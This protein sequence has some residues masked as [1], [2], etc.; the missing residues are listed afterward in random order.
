MIITLSSSTSDNSLQYTLSLTQNL[1]N[2]LA[3]GNLF[4]GVDTGGADCIVN[5]GASP[6][7]HTPPSGYKSI[8]S[9]NLPDGSITKPSQYFDALKY[10]GS[11]TTSQSSLDFEPD[12]VWTKS[13][14]NNDT[15][16][17]WD[18]VRGAEKYLSTENTN[19]EGTNTSGLTSFD[20]NGFSY[21]SWGPLKNGS[22]S[23]WCWDAGTAFS[24][25]AGT[26]FA[27]IASSGRANN[28]SGFSITTY[29]GNG[30]SSGAKV[31]HGL[32]QKPDA[33]II[34]S[35]DTTYSWIV[36]HKEFSSTELIYLNHNYE[37]QTGKA[38]HFNSTCRR[39][40][41]LV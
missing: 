31:Y 9:K 25:S 12:F 27:T 33:L 24:N 6:F 38:D 37:K 17:L 3:A 21:G 35:R 14:S 23:A 41:F 32:N 30:S 20:S 2:E 22:M 10:N 26:N 1:Q 11:N 13:R 15:H 28:T 40:V 19:I 8:C 16:F 29:T 34:K 18:Q 39:L 7:K 4:P 5:F 36:W